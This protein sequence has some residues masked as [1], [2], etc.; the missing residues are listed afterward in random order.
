MNSPHTQKNLGLFHKNPYN[1]QNDNKMIQNDSSWKTQ[2]LS[3][4]H[5]KSL[6]LMLQNKPTFF[7]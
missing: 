1:K 5:P 2:A 6:V 4:N 3:L 7:Q